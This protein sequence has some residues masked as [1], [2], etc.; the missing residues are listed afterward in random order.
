[1][2]NAQA[3]QQAMTPIQE[4]RHTFGK[5]GAELQALFPTK[6]HV[7]RF[8]RVVMTAIQDKP[9]LLDC[10]KSTLYAAAFK[11]AQDGLLPDGREAHLNTRNVNVS[12]VKDKPQWELHAT[13][14]PM[15]E[16]LLKK[17]RNSGMCLGVPNV[18]VVRVQDQFR[19]VLG[20]N[21]HIEHEAPL[22]DRGNVV[23]A[24]SI[25]TLKDG[26]VSREVMSIEEILEIRNISKAKDG[27]PWKIVDGKHS[28][29]F[30]EQCRK[31]VFRR[32]YKKLPRSTDLD[33][34]INTDNEQYD[35]ERAPAASEPIDVSTPQAPP[36]QRAPNGKRRPKALAAVAEAGGTP[37]PIQ[38]P[39]AEQ[40]EHVTVEGNATR[41]P[42]QQ[43]KPQAD[44][45]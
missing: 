33:N 3:Q 23:A 1:M 9:E 20:D 7:D 19:Y 18:Q 12:K 39:K 14:E 28:S 10:T 42:E 5:M 37:S 30:G 2:S 43:Q 21:P 40:R 13:Y 16:G 41:E 45:I 25:V 35:C 32:H 34:V 22:G 24:Y 26:T 6:E 29:V 36:P 11:C 4:I 38:T 8:V 15:V 44:V 31:T 27:G 17:F